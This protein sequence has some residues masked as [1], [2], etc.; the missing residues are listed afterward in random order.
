MVECLMKGRQNHEYGEELL[1]G[2]VHCLLVQNVSEG[3]V[4]QSFHPTNQTIQTSTSATGMLGLPRAMKDW[5]SKSTLCALLSCDV[6][7]AIAR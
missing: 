1:I 2:A 6:L 7:A 5:A 4:A 3:M